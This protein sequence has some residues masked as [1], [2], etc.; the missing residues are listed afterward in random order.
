MHNSTIRLGNAGCYRNGAKKFW[1][2]TFHIGIICS[3]RI[4][5]HV[6]QL[7]KTDAQKGAL[8]VNSLTILM[9]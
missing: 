9:K 3:T 4:P 8:V 5:G 7:T 6:T 2:L 1:D